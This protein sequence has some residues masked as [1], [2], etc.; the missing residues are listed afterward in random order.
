MLKGDKDQPVRTS[1]KLSK[2][3]AKHSDAFEVQKARTVIKNSFQSTPNE[4]SN[5]GT[6]SYVRLTF[7]GRNVISF[8]RS[9]TT[10]QTNYFSHLIRYL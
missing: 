3:V 1:V 4:S 10:I 2:H 6:P 8:C 5:D 7:G 9:T